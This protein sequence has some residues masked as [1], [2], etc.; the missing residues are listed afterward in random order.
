MSASKLVAADRRRFPR[1][2]FSIRFS[3]SMSLALTAVAC[4]SDPIA[5]DNTYEALPVTQQT[6]ESGVQ[7]MTAIPVVI[8]VDCNSD[9]RVNCPGGV[10]GSPGSLNVTPTSLTVTPVST[11]VYS[12]VTNVQVATAS[13]ITVSSQGVKCTVAI[14]S[15]AG[16]SSTVRLNGD[17]TFR[18]H[19]RGS[20]VDQ[21]RL[22]L[23]VSGWEGEDITIGGSDFCS[24]ASEQVILDNLND[25][26]QQL[27]VD[28]C[29]AQGPDLFVDCTAPAS[30]ALRTER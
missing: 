2:L 29:G 26:L 22:T 25:Q 17:A 20:P 6:V 11:G 4:G 27:A 18:K 12:Y 3:A 19:S 7:F 21:L 15:A 8:P 28:L 13:D 14:N 24:L 1:R 5:P 9:P 10:A 30:A 16:T 23:S